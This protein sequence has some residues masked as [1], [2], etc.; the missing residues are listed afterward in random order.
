M[1]GVGLESG[2]C[3]VHIA[4][5]LGRSP[6]VIRGRDQAQ[7]GRGRVLQGRGGMA[8]GCM[9]PPHPSPPH[10]DARAR[11]RRTPMATERRA[12]AK[13]A[14]IPQSASRGRSASADVEVAA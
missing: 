11:V 6:S 5:V 3:Q 13:R 10:S 4:R 9:L 7:R 8:H 14:Q 12:K 2:L 1:A